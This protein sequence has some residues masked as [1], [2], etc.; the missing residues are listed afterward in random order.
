MVSPGR[1][2]LG[3]LFALLLVVVGLYYGLPVVRDYW[4][5]YRLVDEMKTNARFGLTM[6]DEEMLRRLRL[7]VVELDL[8]EEAKRFTIRRS[9]F[10]PTVSVR[11]QY[12][13]LI[14]LPFT[15]KVITFRPSVEVR[16]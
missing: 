10:P 5:Y 11:T 7:A 2:R 1:G 3:C 9:K 12:H 16:Q 8:P 13:Q 6:S 15:R 4:N 14:D